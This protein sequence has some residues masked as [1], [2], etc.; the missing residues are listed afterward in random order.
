MSIEVELINHTPDPVGTV[1]TLW[2]AS[3]HNEPL[4][5][6]VEA[7]E[8]EKVFLQVLDSEIPIAE[9]VVFVFMLEGVPISL[10]EQMVRHRVGHH[11]GGRLGADIVPD[12]Q[13][14]SWWAQSMRVLNMGT[15]ASENR[16][17]LPSTTYDQ[18]AVTEEES[19]Y[20][21]AMHHAQKQYNKLVELGVPAEDAR[22]VIPLGATHRLS[23][24][25]NLAALMH[26]L[27]HRT[28]WMAQSDT[29]GPLIRGMMSEIVEKVDPVFERITRPPCIDVEGRHTGCV[30]GVANKAHIAGNDDLPPC[31]LWLAYH[32]DEAKEASKEAEDTG[33]DPW[34]STSDVDMQWEAPSDEL[35]RN[36]IRILR[37]KLKLWGQW[38][39]KRVEG[40]VE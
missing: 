4:K 22:N 15:F 23:W 30:M 39:A 5:D 9:S 20:R 27:G 17:H 21:A 2:Q 32:R 40:V 8:A 14:S 18:D 28:C 34:K 26:V 35:K 12:L 1:Y 36:Y 19:V 29:W 16:F 6:P 7:S 31:P 11:F 25:L 10:R 33:C 38:V 3:R 37:E 24:T 13:D